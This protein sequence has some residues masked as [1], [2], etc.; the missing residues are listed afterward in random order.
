M[1]NAHFLHFAVSQ[2]GKCTFSLFCKFPFW[3]SAFPLGKM[4]LQ[5]CISTFPLGKMTLQLYISTFP[6]GKMTLQ[7]CI[8]AFPLGK[9]TLQLCISTF[10]LGKMTLQLYISIFPLGKMALQ[11]CIS[12]FPL[13]K[14]VPRFGMNFSTCM[15]Y[16]ETGICRLGVSGQF[17][18]WKSAAS[19]H[20]NQKAKL[21]SHFSK[22]KS[23]IPKWGSSKTVF[24]SFPFWG[25]L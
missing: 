9:M 6:L 3:D 23:Q 7:L 15:S 25:N 13:G 21:Q 14:M 11:L 20:K 17:S 1:G 12:I 16:S 18:K 24:W 2:F 8:S 5:L 10:P 4:T 22:W 19:R